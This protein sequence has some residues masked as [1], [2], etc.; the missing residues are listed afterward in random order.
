MAAL[1]RYPVKAMGGESL[2]KVDLDDRGLVGDRW[3]AVTDDDG[4]FAALKNT[5][6]F[7]RRDRVVDY[8]ASTTADTVVVACA[9]DRWRVGDPALDEHLSTRLGTRVRV[10]AEDTAPHQDGGAVS[11]IGS[12]TLQWCAERWGPAGDARRLRAN[13][14]VETS[15]P[16]EEEDWV[17]STVRIGTAALHIVERVRRC[18]V[19]DVAQ[20]GVVP[21]ASWLK[22]LGRERD[23]LLA[24]YADVTGRGVIALG[25][26]PRPGR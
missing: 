14:V 8:R 2:R 24:V 13:I 15:V 11:L 6:R 9:E 21:Q 12:A 5:R 18:R 17:G 3:F 19:I 20:D 25:D 23:L 10:T 26:P 22:E 1:R 16:F 4:R 7:K